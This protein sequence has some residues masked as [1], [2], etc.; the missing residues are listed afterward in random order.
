MYSV[1]NKVTHGGADKDEGVSM[2]ETTNVLNV[3][4]QWPVIKLVNKTARSY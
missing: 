3:A 1:P 4:F 2:K